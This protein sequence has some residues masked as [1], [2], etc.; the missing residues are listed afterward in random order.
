MNDRTGPTR[1]TTILTTVAV[2]AAAGCG[3]SDG[4]PLDPDTEFQL[5]VTI[6]A[7]GDAT[8][9]VTT[10]SGI[11]Q[12]RICNEGDACVYSIAASASTG[13]FAQPGL[14]SVFVEW[15]GDC[16]GTS[17]QVTVTAA[18]GE[19]VACTA[20]F[21]AEDPPGDTI[22]REGVDAISRRQCSYDSINEFF[23]CGGAPGGALNVNFPTPELAAQLVSPNPS[24]Y[25][26]VG[27]TSFPSLDLG[28]ITLESSVMDTT[29]THD[30]TGYTFDTLPASTPLAVTDTLT[31]TT[32]GG[33]VT[34]DAPPDDLIVNE[35]ASGDVVVQ[36]GFASDLWRV[37]AFGTTPGGAQAGAICQFPGSDELEVTHDILIEAVN[38]AGF[39]PSAIWISAANAAE[40][41][42][43][44][45]P[46]VARANRGLTFFGAQLDDLGELDDVTTPP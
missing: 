8:G 44:D 25:T 1:L 16:S 23:Q 2:L 7:P 42:I 20:T 14:G 24:C 37:M 31:V 6:V 5:T 43:G 28:V 32:T 41:P 36:T 18:P 33:A 10:T 17:D 40:L 29:A 15:S 35:N 46:P 22:A 12:I 19:A 30:G 45:V 11:D 3:N 26:F 4:D 39:R 27:V 13:M 9:S 21:A 34:I 38:A